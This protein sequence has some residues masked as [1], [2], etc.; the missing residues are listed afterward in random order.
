MKDAYALARWKTSRDRFLSHAL[1]IF[2]NNS[3]AKLPN[4]S[5]DQL[6]ENAG[7]H[8]L[9]CLKCVYTYGNAFSCQQ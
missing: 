3:I 1:S 4:N 7:L 5:G 6:W 2:S 8:A 9:R